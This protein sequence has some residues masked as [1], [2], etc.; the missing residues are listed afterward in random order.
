MLYQ[1]EITLTY[2]KGS[3]H[4]QISPTYIHTEEYFRVR[5]MVFNAAFYNISVVLW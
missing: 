2:L 3:T 4:D 5:V 1:I